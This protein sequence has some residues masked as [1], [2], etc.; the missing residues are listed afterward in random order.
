MESD[1]TTPPNHQRSIQDYLS[2]GYLYLL[3][4]GI[5]TDSIYFGFIGI[6]ILEYSTIVDV[7][8]SPV[9]YLTK[10]LTFPLVI[11][12][13]PI[14]GIGLMHLRNR[15]AQKKAAAAFPKKEEATELENAKAGSQ[16]VL[17][18]FVAVTIFSAYFGYGLGGGQAMKERIQSGSFKLNHQLT[19]N[20]GEELDIYLIDHNS[21]YVFYVTENSKSVTVSPVEGNIKKIEKLEK[22]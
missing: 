19:F 18:V 13:T 5:T 8:L 15:Q 22:E 2:L 7:I 4:L 9:I 21:L 16:R 11:F 17:L 14:L 10:S 20:D 12:L 6:N 3:L 1:K